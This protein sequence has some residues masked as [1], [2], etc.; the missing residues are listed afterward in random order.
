M[1]ARKHTPVKMLGRFGDLVALGLSRQQIDDAVASG[2]LRIL[3]RSPKQ[4]HRYFDM[5]DAYRLMGYS[6]VNGLIPEAQLTSRITELVSQALRKVLPALTREIV[7]AEVRYTLN[8][9]S[10]IWGKRAEEQLARS[11]TTTRPPNADP[12]SW[13]CRGGGT[14]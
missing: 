1:P 9:V 12:T 2:E 13:H 14:Y 4:G 11:T 10:P 6:G 8:T 3:K 5:M 7:T